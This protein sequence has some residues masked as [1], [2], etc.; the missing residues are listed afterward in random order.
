LEIVDDFDGETY[1]AVYTVKFANVVYV[2]HVC[3]SC[4]PEEIA[5]GNRN[6]AER[7][8]PDPAALPLR[9][10]GAQCIESEIVKE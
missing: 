5:K 3:P 1:R 6:G 7:D 9:R 4:I 10:S 8:R 2:L